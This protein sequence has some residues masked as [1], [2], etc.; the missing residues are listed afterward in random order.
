MVFTKNKNWKGSGRL[1]R[2]FIADCK[3]EMSLR[4]WKNKDLAKATGYKTNTIDS[5]FSERKDRERSEDVGK[6]IGKVLGI[7]YV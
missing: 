3:R 4:G 5:F 2:V 6:A 7:D 1:D